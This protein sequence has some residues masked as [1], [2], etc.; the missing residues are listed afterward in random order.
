MGGAWSPGLYCINSPRIWGARFW[1]WRG[2]DSNG[3]AW[4]V[5]RAARAKR[6]LVIGF[7]VSGLWRLT[8]GI[9]LWTSGNAAGV[10]RAGGRSGRLFSASGCGEYFEARRI[11]ETWKGDS[12]LFVASK[13]AAWYSILVL[14]FISYFRKRVW[15]W[16]NSNNWQWQYRL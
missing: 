1:I 8:S 9:W 6:P 13:P 7:W 3:T 14:V 16:G 10:S 12:H 5:F 4:Y 11:S 2:A 15:V